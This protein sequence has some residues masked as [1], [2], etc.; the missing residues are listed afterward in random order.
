MKKLL[1]SL[2]LVFGLFGCATPA[3][4]VPEN[5]QGVFCT[6]VETLTTKVTTVFANK[7]LGKVTASPDCAVTIKTD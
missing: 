4:T 7:D 5:V 3:S 1:A 6:S 2:I